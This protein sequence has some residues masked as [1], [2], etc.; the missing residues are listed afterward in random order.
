MKMSYFQ[1]DE[2][3]LIHRMNRPPS[4]ITRAHQVYEKGRKS[5]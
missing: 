4:I 1:V 3:I 2:T 5:P